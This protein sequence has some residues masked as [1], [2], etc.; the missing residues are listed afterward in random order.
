MGMVLAVRHLT[1]GE[2]FAVKIMLPEMRSHPEAVGRFLREAQASARLRSEHVARVHD[3]GTLDD[4]IPYMVLEYLEGIDLDQLLISRGALGVSEAAGYVFQAC[5]ALIEAHGRGIVHRD[6]KPANLF[7]TRRANGSACI[8]VL[9]FGISKE[10]GAADKNAPKLTQT[11]A[12]MGSPHY[13]SPEQMVD[14]KNVDARCDIWAMGIILYELVTATMPFQADTM[15]EIVAKVLSMQPPPPSHV[16][17][18]IAP[19]FDA[20]VARCT[21]KNRDNRYQSVQEFMTALRPF[22]TE[23]DSQASATIQVIP[24]ASAGP[25]MIG[26]SAVGW[27]Q[28]TVPSMPVETGKPARSSSGRIGMIAAIVGIVVMLVVVAWVMRPKGHEREA[29]AGVPSSRPADAKPAASALD[30]TAAAT[31]EKAP[32]SSASTTMASTPTKGAIRP[33]AA[34]TTTVKTKKKVKG[35]DE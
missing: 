24:L 16:R 3:V 22:V 17:A 34:V 5:E 21:E 9:D 13:M 12:I 7:L 19:A 33:P 29:H 23:G 25:S 28:A 11:G 14:S 35:F 6:L 18:G 32:A 30:V 27:G 8:K 2:L 20:V 31:A 4:G 15:P 26:Q 1:L 10:M